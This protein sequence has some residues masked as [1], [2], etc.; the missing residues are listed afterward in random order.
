MKDVIRSHGLR[1]VCSVWRHKTGANAPEKGSSDFWNSS[2]V[3]GSWRAIICSPPMQ[4][5]GVTGLLHPPAV[6]T[7]LSWIIPRVPRWNLPCRSNTATISVNPVHITSL[8]GR[9]ADMI[10]GV[11]V[12]GGRKGGAP[13]GH[14]VGA[15]EW[16]VDAQW[17]ATLHKSVRQR[18]A[19]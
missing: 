6:P 15:A 17:L 14:V 5:A 3:P 4:T 1:L 12:G 8:S 18:C 16:D 11:H 13:E 9:H 7:S 19:Y 10:R 2:H